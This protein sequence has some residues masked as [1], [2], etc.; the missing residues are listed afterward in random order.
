MKQNNTSPNTIK[1][2]WLF[3][4]FGFYGFTYFA[5]RQPL[6]LFWFSFFSFFAYYFIGKMADEMQDERYLENSQRAKLKTAAIPLVA[7]FIIGFG[8]GFPFVTKEMIILACAVGWAATLV[9]Y[10]ILFWH[11][12]KN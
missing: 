9:S 4:F 7:L 3:G 11:Y 6:S 2:V 1:Y 10:A 12:D 8:S 5:T